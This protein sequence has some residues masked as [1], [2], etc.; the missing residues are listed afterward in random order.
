MRVIMLDNGL[1]SCG[2]HSYQLLLEVCGAL[3]QRGHPH[4]V[5]GAKD[6]DAVVVRDLDAVPWFT[7]SLY[8]GCRRRLPSICNVVG[9]TATLLRDF[10]R[11]GRRSRNQIRG[12]S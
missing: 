3:S 7:R 4:R 12:A 6:M 1:V 5:F 11:A 10:L 2:E 8:W 9:D